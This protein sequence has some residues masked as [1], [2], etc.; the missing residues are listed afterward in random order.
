MVKSLGVFAIPGIADIKPGD[1]LAGLICAAAAPIGVETNDIVVVAQKVVS[2]AE[3]AI[4]RLSDITPSDEAVRVA[5][6]TGKSPAL[7]EVILSQSQRIVRLQQGVLITETIHGFVCANAGVDASNIAGDDVVSLLPE[8]SDASAQRIRGALEERFSAHV[9]VI[10]SDSFNRPWRMGSVNVAIGV[11]GFDPLGDY[12]G[13]ADDNG[14]QLKSTLVSVADEVASAAQLV[15]GEFGRVP[16]AIVRGLDLSQQD[17][18][19]QMLL[20]DAKRDL[21]R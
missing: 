14:V 9:G 16:V 6:E 17:G 13:Q 7:I 20:R 18:N 2:K 10:V 3:G 5:E 1:D 4:V 11:A 12:R 21:F 8:D 15:M 19:G